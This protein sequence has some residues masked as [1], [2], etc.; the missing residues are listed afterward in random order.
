MITSGEAAQARGEREAF[1]LTMALLG[2]E[3]YQQTPTSCNVLSTSTL[4]TRLRC[5]FAFQLLR[6]DEI[7]R[8]P[9]D[10]SFFDLTVR[11]GEIVRASQRWEI[12]KFSPE[13][14]E[15]FAKWVSKAHPRDAAVCTPTR[16]TPWSVSLRNPSGSRTGARASTRTV[17]AARRDDREALRRRVRRPN[18]ER[19]A[20]YL[21]DD[22]YIFEMIC[23]C[24]LA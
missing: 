18:A 9:F 1:R 24:H 11:D 6:S 13:V 23:V 10:G 17:T 15:P 8:G 21:A 2:A 22:A 4:G 12:K 16:R 5:P 14:W 20:S 19:A 3:G 7:G